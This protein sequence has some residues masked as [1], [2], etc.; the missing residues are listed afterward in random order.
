M[1]R[2]W[3]QVRHGHSCNASCC[4]AECQGRLRHRLKRSRSHS[5]ENRLHP[6]HKRHIVRQNNR[7]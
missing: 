6:D 1:G 5:Q 2:G 4:L 3:A 7:K